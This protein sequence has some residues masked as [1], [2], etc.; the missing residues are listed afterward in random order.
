MPRSQETHFAG[1]SFDLVSSRDQSLG[2]FEDNEE[3]YGALFALLARPINAEEPQSSPL[4]DHDA[5]VEVDDPS[6]KIV[7]EET[8]FENSALE[9]IQSLSNSPANNWSP[10]SEDQPSRQNE[11]VIDVDVAVESLAT[12]S[13]FFETTTFRG[14]LDLAETGYQQSETAQTIANEP[15]AR[16]NFATDIPRELVEGDDTSELLLGTFVDEE[17]RANGDNDTIL[18]AGG[19]DLLS[20]GDGN[21]LVVSISGTNVISGGAGSDIL[22]GGYQDDI[23]NGNGGNDLIRG[24]IATHLAGRDVLIGGEGDDILEGG[25]SADLFVFS[26]GDGTDF[27]VEYYFEFGTSGA[28]DVIG[29]DFVVGLDQ[30]LLTDFGYASSVEA[31]GNFTDV[32]GFA[33]FTDQGT[34]F[35]IWGVSVADLSADDIVLV[36]TETSDSGDEDVV[37]SGNLTDPSAVLPERFGLV[38][39]PENG[40]VTVNA[41]GSYTYTPF[42]DFN[43]A[44]RFTYSVTD[45]NGG[46]S[47]ETVEL[48]INPVNDAPRDLTSE[49]TTG[50]DTPLV[51][52]LSAVDIEGDA[53]TFSLIDVAETGTV[54]VNADGEFEYTPATGFL[55]QD[56]FSYCVSDGNGGTTT[57]TVTVTVNVALD[58]DNAAVGNL[59]VSYPDATTLDFLLTTSPE[60][61]S[62][63]I[64]ADGTFTYT[65][66]DDFNGSDS[67]SY[68]VSVDGG[69]PEIVTINIDVAPVNDAPEIQPISQTD[70]TET[71]DTQNIAGDVD[72]TFTDVDVGDVGHTATVTALGPTGDLAGLTLD[73]AGLEALL[74]L[75]DVMKTGDVATGSVN[76]SFNAASTVFDYLGEGDQVT[77]SYELMIDD[78]NGGTDVQEFD[79]VI[80]GTFD[81]VAPFDLAEVALADNDTGYVINGSA[82]NSE[83]G[84][85][86]SLAGDVNGDGFDDLFIGATN[87]QI[88]GGGFVVF[89]Q[90]DGAPVEL[91]DIANGIG[92]FL[93]EGDPFTGSSFPS[94]SNAGDVNGDGLDDVIIGLRDADPN[95][96]Q[97]G[98]SYVVFGKVDG[99]AVNLTD[100]ESGS[101]GFVI[102]GSAN[103]E[104]TGMS[105]SGAGDINGDGLADLFIGTEN[106]TLT[107]ASAV[108]GNGAGYVVFGKADGSA[109]E[110]SDIRDGIGGFAITGADENDRAGISVSNAGD[111]NGDGFDD[112]I[113]GAKFA[114][115]NGSASGASYVV[116]GK[117]DGTAVDLSDVEQG[118]GGFVINGVLAFDNS[119]LS[120]SDAGD[121]NGDGLADL[122]VGAPFTDLDD[123]VTG[124]LNG[125]S[126]IVFG[127]VDGAAVELSDVI[128]GIG[129]FAFIG[130]DGR[131]KLGRSVSSAGDVNG[132]GLA[133]VI[134][135]SGDTGLGINKSF[136]IFGKADGEAVLQ[137]DIEAGIG[138]FVI[139]AA[140]S[141]D[142]MGKS[143]SGAGD[144]NGDGFDDLIVG[145]PD[146]DSDGS[147]ILDNSG[148]SFVIFGGDFTGAATQIGSAGNDSIVGQDTAEA[149]F[150]AAGDDTISGN[151]GGDR[152]S[153]GAGSDT[154]IFTNTDSLET[155]VDF[156]DGIGGQDIIDVSAYGFAAAE[157]VLD[158]AQT[159]GPGGHDV[160]IQLDADNAILIQDFDLS[161]LDASDF[162]I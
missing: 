106:A 17:I 79:F 40:I 130:A 52:T 129:G 61:G 158:L 42:A 13:A 62:M 107:G 12:S 36:T 26:T 87:G 104:K 46:V 124:A 152:L 24:D 22:I 71:T 123:T 41:D 23:I 135:G 64:N 31:L 4:N 140:Q 136:V 119:G 161:Q 8:R 49:L 25:G 134:I 92:G 110:I 65:P 80:T 157:D 72:L 44:D 21:D 154:F 54:T 98:A 109:V 2:L 133:D 43:G 128:D 126:Y 1:G 81:A 121:V 101:G 53:L 69:L 127:K 114:D 90:S 89:G 55:G 82:P 97:S 122:I 85:A 14:Q 75:G 83:S 118:T 73:A 63:M 146:G 57:E 125:S 60:N 16:V 120:V 39:N 3:R 10:M 84:S 15:A 155:I 48:T 34:Q 86:V 132:D 141:A 59:A 148:T 9:Q 56:S 66:P 37:L 78:G 32:D 95:G 29:A 38:V 105:V 51:G 144:I 149:L 138:G 30:I 113:I 27:I 77:I 117:A 7:Q 67:F 102:N 74:T 47:Y 68:S 143:V 6:Q 94:V 50:S 131:E 111:V 162:I 91:S 150:G 35:T 156:E 76:V 112:L 103:F 93:I 139:T 116:F 160:L 115:P 58:E 20:G 100:V 88:A 108:G 19:N 99:T 153:G 147:D 28:F 151:G 137:S 96:I 5:T 142:D 18:N 145:A 33:T 45:S 159:S 11:R 70:I